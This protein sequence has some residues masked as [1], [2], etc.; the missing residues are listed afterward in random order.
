MVILFKKWLVYLVRLATNPLGPHRCSLAPKLVKAV[1]AAV[2]IEIV[3]RPLTEDN[4]QHYHWHAPPLFEE[5]LAFS[6]HHPQE[7]T[8][9]K[10]FE[11][12]LQKIK[13]NG[14]YETLSRQYE[15]QLG[16][17]GLSR[18]CWYRNPTSHPRRYA[19]Q[20]AAHRMAPM[21]EQ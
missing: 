2:G 3:F 10:R 20:P 8:L 5:A 4:R 6:R 13:N 14:T 7:E 1:F 16:L 11:Q 9:A 21:I 12:G 19:G 18:P 15:T 17:H